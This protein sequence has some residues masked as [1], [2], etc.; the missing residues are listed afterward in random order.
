MIV[1]FDLQVWIARHE[2]GKK[3]K[4]TPDTSH[5]NH[6]VC[7]ERSAAA[8]CINPNVD[9]N[10]KKRLFCTAA[11][12]KS[13]CALQTLRFFIATFA[14]VRGR[15]RHVWQLCGRKEQK[16][17]CRGL[18]FG[19]PTYL[20]Q[21]EKKY[22]IKDWTRLSALLCS[23]ALQSKPSGSPAVHFWVLQAGDHLF[24]GTKT[25]PKTGF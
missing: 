25:A 18:V 5:N 13:V 6:H 14:R 24:G 2:E 4:N 23:L 20:K 19:R 8:E 22:F 16:K 7:A 12:D 1:Y 21:P 15:K 9:L 3:K 17:R 11:G 10:N